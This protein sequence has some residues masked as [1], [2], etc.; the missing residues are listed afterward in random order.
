MRALVFAIVLCVPQ[1]RAFQFGSG[2][3]PGMQCPY[4]FSPAPGAYDGNDEIRNLVGGLNNAQRKLKMNETKLSDLNKRIDAAKQKMRRVIKSARAMQDI[5]TH[6]KHNLNP[7]DYAASCG[8]QEQNDK[9]SDGYRL[10]EKKVVE[11]RAIHL[12]AERYP[13]ISAIRAKTIGRPSLS[14]TVWS[15]NPSAITKSLLLLKVAPQSTPVVVMNVVRVL[16][17][18]T[19]S[20]PRKKN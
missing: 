14:Q 12:T 11:T 6:Y 13:V 15:M 5:E 1:A 4:P 2:M 17:I 19:N 10:P 18:T 3:A 20:W 16:R 9:S 7:E 8:R